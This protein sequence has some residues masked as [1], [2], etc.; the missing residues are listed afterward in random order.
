MTTSATPGRHFHVPADELLMD[1]PARC[2][3]LPTLT[4]DGIAVTAAGQHHLILT[5]RDRAR[6]YVGPDDATVDR[7]AAIMAAALTKH[8][9][10]FLADLVGEWIR[11]AWDALL[12]QLVEQL[13]AGLT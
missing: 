2:D 11:W 13:T 3:F 5:L 4:L 1:Q 7:R 10:A 8:L 6:I 12:D 9:G